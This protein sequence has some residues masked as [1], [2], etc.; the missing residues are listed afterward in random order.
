[1]SNAKRDQNSVPTLLGVSSVDGVTP[2]LIAVN[3]ST[4][5]V[6]VDLA[7]AGGGITSI[8]ADTTVAQTL[9]TGTTGTD[10]A[11]VDNGTGDHAFNLPS[12][13]ATARGLITTGT[14]TIAG[15]KT[16]TGA[17]TAS[18]LSGTNT[19]NQ[20]ITLT[21]DVTG[22]GTGSFASTLATVN[23]NVGSFTNAS[24]TVNAKGLITAASSGSSGTGSVTT[25]SVATA[26]GFSGSVANP[27]TTPAITLSVN[28][29][30]SRREV[31]AFPDDTI[32]ATIDIQAYSF[33]A[34]KALWYQID[35]SGVLVL[36]NSSSYG[37]NFYY[38]AA[39]AALMR[40]NATETYVTFTTGSKTNVGTMTADATKRAN[41]TAALRNFCIDNKFTG[42][43]IDAEVF[44]IPGGATGTQYTNFKTWITELG[45]DLHSYG[46]KLI[47]DAPPIWNSS[48]SATPPEW[49]GRN[50]QGYYTFKYEDFNALP[51]DYLLPLAYDYQNDEGAGTPNQPITWMQDIATWAKSK[52]TNHDR[53]IIGLPAAGYS[54]ATGGFTTTGHNFDYLAAQT[55]YGG[56]SRD[57]DSQELIWANAGISYAA[58]DDV[59]MVAKIQGAEQMGISRISQW[60]AGNNRYGSTLFQNITPLPLTNYAG[61]TPQFAKVSIGAAPGANALYVSGTGYTGGVAVDAS[62]SPTP[63]TNAYLH[64]V[65]GTIVEASSGTHNL[66]ASEFI[67]IA[68]VTAGAATVAN[69]ASLYIEG[70]MGGSVSGA[71]YAAWVDAGN[72][73]IDG[74]LTDGTV[75]FPL[76][77]ISTASNAQTLTNKTLTSSTNVLGGVT[78]TLGSDATGDV[79]YRTG[80]VLTRLG[81]GST[82][83]VLTV[84]GGIPSW[85]DN[86]SSPASAL[87]SFPQPTY[88]VSGTSSSQ[89]LA[90]NTTMIIGSVFLANP[91]TVNKV[92]I[93]IETY[94]ATGTAKIGLWSA[95]GST[96]V[97]SATTASITNE[98]LYTTTLGSPV[99]LAAGQYYLGIVATGTSNFGTDT[100][101]TTG[102]DTFGTVTSEPKIE[103]TYTVT[104]GTLPSSITPTSITQSQ[105]HT[106][107]VRFDN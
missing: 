64:N 11:I 77:T 5:R 83:Q 80:G 74:S 100:W 52:I 65:T 71:N 22:S 8:N 36:R 15:A 32:D 46:F 106:P 96:L 75:T 63:S 66:L 13:S 29:A 18:N 50:S 101:N 9:S 25:V 54:G 82:N 16:F 79:Y 28:P 17:I 31:W 76:N 89:S 51:V 35:S 12:A 61:Q 34:V 88:P 47:V 48:T 41:A 91:I 43:E 44:S 10:F 60:Y 4:G 68:T 21:G 87:V 78:M 49:N 73:R 40:A 7:G 92:S 23:S 19:G 2:T 95:D 69:T 93:K 58:I 30:S 39:N 90:T 103:G 37:A 99:V 84:S 86:S 3:P 72:V 59:A 20:T 105:G 55:G 81:I 6:L 1:M 24:V 14:Q 26:N 56:A 98:N 104:A 67:G 85:A 45:N 62:L 102:S 33:Y 97:L 42:V 107:I 94:S 38:T 27:T 57:S 70:A 53:I